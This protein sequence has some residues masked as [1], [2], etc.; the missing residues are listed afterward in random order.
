MSRAIGI[1]LEK[2]NSS[3][4]RGDNGCED[5]TIDNCT[6][7]T[8]GTGIHFGQDA[9][10]CDV[11]TT[12][13]ALSS[14][15]AI[16]E[17]SDG[18]GYHRFTGLYI[19]LDADFSGSHL[20]YLTCPGNSVNDCLIIDYYSSTYPTVNCI[21]FD[22]AAHGSEASHNVIRGCGGGGAT[23]IY[24]LADYT[25]IQDNYFENTQG[26]GKDIYI[27]ASANKT[28]VTGNH[29][30]VDIDDDGSNTWIDTNSNILI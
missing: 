21:V 27:A 6:I 8:V 1:D 17:D 19:D 23:G 2:A 29:Y 10:Y 13:I 11:D 24:V 28:I 7:F 20:I 14:S 15:Y 3:Y 30:D 22:S 16:N 9:G 4:R 5:I 12:E 25:R 26:A 18:D